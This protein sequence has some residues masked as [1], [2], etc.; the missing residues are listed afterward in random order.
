MTA[1]S[2]PA[3]NGGPMKR[4]SGMPGTGLLGGC[5][6]SHASWGTL[7][8]CAVEVVAEEVE[9]EVERASASVATHGRTRGMRCG[10]PA[11]RCGMCEGDTRKDV[12]VRGNVGDERKSEGWMKVSNDGGGAGILRRR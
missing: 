10:V 4:Q 2:G 6:G 7:R 9:E 12:E 5:A 3:L 8:T 11:W 1:G